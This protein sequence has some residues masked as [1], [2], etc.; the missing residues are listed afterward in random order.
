MLFA[1]NNYI[2][3][4]AKQCTEKGTTEIFPSFLFAKR[5]VGCVP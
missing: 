5:S 1:L 2:K 3:R 4:D